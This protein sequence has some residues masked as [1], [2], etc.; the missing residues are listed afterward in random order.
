MVTG[1]IMF[2][3]AA[4]VTAFVYILFFRNYSLFEGSVPIGIQFGVVLLASVFLGL[5]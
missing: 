5:Y 2:Q 4:T 3:Q 1:H